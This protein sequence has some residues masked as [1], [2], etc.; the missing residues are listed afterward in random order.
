M[1]NLNLYRQTNLSSI[2]NINQMYIL[3]QNR[4]EN[5]HIIFV[6]LPDHVMPFTTAITSEFSK[7]HIF[8]MVQTLLLTK[9]V[10]YL[11]A[12]R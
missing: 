1:R 5:V 3:H 11:C 6:R 2:I 7:C 12:V 8:D 9:K 10:S 4:M